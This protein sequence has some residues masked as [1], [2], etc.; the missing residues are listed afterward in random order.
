[1]ARGIRTINP[2]SVLNSNHQKNDEDNSP[3]KVCTLYLFSP[4]WP[5]STVSTEFKHDTEIKLI[6]I[7]R[8]N[9]QSI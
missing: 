6:I 4:R 1:M 3:N 5:F 9:L 7:I 8:P 2:G